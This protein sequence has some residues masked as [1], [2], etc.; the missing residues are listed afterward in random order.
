MHVE[1]L[2]STII[3][4]VGKVV[5]RLWGWGGRI[6]MGTQPTQRQPQNAATKSMLGGQTKATWSP[7]LRLPFSRMSVAT[8]SARLCN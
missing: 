6:M 4:S 3:L 8:L 2:A 7:T 5:D 1:L